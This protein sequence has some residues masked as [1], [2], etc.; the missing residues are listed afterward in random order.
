[1]SG[2][3]WG[4]KDMQLIIGNL[5]RG[6]VLLSTGIVIIGGIVYLARHGQELPEYGTFH[7]QP[8]EFR[9]IPG[10]ARGVWD[11]KGRAVIQMGI[12]VLIATPV[13]RVAFSIIGY[14]LEKDYLYTAITLLVLAIILF[15]MLG[16]LG[17]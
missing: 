2:K 4:D 9:T 14:L 12:L 6:G 5:L 11:G 13:F 15:S 10:I 8:R 17:A 16:G 1:M 3:K 7:G